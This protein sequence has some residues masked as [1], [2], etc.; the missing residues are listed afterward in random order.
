MTSLAL[1]VIGAFQLPVP[2][3]HRRLALSYTERWFCSIRKLDS[4]IV[5]GDI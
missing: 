5:I 1:S 4:R 3:N 2:P